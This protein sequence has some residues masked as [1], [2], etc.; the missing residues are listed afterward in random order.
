MSEVRDAGCSINEGEANGCEGEHETEIETRDESLNDLVRDAHRIAFA[1]ADKEVH[2]Y[3]TTG[4]DG[5]G[6][7]VALDKLSFWVVYNG[8][9]VGERFLVNSDGVVGIPFGHSS[10]PLAFG[11]GQ[12]LG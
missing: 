9:A 11:I 2:G 5:N 1:L 7:D 10:G 4:A 12:N 3:S 6:L 8:D